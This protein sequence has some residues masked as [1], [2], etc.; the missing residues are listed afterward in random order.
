MNGA[1]L[2]LYRHNTWATLRLIDHCRGLDEGLLDASMP[3]TYGSILDTLRHIVES[4]EGY[5]AD[6]THERLSEPLDGRRVT[7]DELEERVRRMAPRWETLARDAEAQDREVTT[8]DG[9]VRVPCA[10]PMAQTI[11]HADDHRTHVLSIL[12]ARGL[13]VP[14]LS[15]WAH[16]RSAGLMQELRAPDE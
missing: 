5:L 12:G 1:L 7:L 2:E 16:A 8:E 15:V 11:H 4:E 3:G 9:G 14:S 13:E 6:V 10:V